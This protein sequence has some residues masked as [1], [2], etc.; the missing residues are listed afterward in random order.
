MVTPGTETQR[1]SYWTPL[2]STC[3]FFLLQGLSVILILAL[4][5]VCLFYRA[6]RKRNWRDLFRALEAKNGVWLVPIN[7]MVFSGPAISFVQ[8]L[9]ILGPLFCPDFKSS[10]FCPLMPS[11]PPPPSSPCLCPFSQDPVFIISQET[12]KSEQTWC[13]FH[14]FNNILCASYC[15]IYQRWHKMVLGRK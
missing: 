5:P 8:L 4:F 12:L 2:F 10:R 1:H 6:G 3:G 9:V 15:D 11:F 7:W 14:L 13:E